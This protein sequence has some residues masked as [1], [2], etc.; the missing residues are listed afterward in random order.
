MPFYM[1]YRHERFLHA[2]YFLIFITE[3]PR[4][5]IIDEMCFTL[6]LTTV[7]HPGYKRKC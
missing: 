1:A 2:C 4:L 3:E 7:N 6:Y 5:S